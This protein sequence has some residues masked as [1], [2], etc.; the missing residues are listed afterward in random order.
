MGGSSR[1]RRTCGASVSHGLRRGVTRTALAHAGFRTGAGNRGGQGGLRPGLGRGAASGPA[2][3]AA[4]QAQRHLRP[5]RCHPS[6]GA[7]PGRPRDA[8]PVGAAAQREHR[9]HHRAGQGPA[10]GRGEPAARR[11]PL[12]QPRPSQPG[13]ADAVHGRRRAG[14][15]V[16]HRPRAGPRAADRLRGNRARAESG[17]QSHGHQR[18]VGRRRDRQ[19]SRHPR[20]GTP[21]RCRAVD[22]ALSSSPLFPPRRVLRPVPTGKAWFAARSTPTRRAT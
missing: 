12:L 10:H 22:A 1:G 2:V 17:R 11:H 9:A 5:G 15:R 6:R 4:G 20:R 8:R 14:H 7:Q 13:G 16:L 19:G 3:V 21:A 18:P